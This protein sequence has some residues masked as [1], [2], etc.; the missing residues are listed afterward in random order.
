M[1]KP[2]PTAAGQGQKQEK[3]AMPKWYRFVC[4]CGY[5]AM[6]YR[7]CKRCPECGGDLVRIEPPTIKTS[8]QDALLS[9]QD[10]RYAMV[11]GNMAE[12]PIPVQVVADW[13]DN[14]EAN[15]TQWR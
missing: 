15:L 3:K 10:A 6:R 13:L 5:N 4:K 1:F 8:I 7:N 12:E 9:V 11:D 2:S 14:I